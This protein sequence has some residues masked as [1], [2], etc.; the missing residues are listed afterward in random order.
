M[1][2]R[3]VQELGDEILHQDPSDSIITTLSLATATARLNERICYGGFSAQELWTQR[4][5]FM[6]EQIPVSDRDVI[7]Q[8]HHKH[9]ANHP[10]SERFKL[11]SGKQLTSCSVDVGDLVYLYC[12]RNKSK[13]RD[14]YLVISVEGDCCNIHKLSGAQLHCNSYHVKHTEC[15]KVLSDLPNST[16]FRYVSDS[17]DEDDPQQSPANAPLE[18]PVIPTEIA[19]PPIPDTPQ[20]P[21]DNLIASQSSLFIQLDPLTQML[22]VLD[23]LTNF[24]V[25]ITFHITANQ[26]RSEE[27]HVP[28]NSL[29]T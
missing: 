22:P 4:N 25:K 1:A 11:P 18:L 8:Q 10:A 16:I 20:Q 3:A 26:N 6:N 29:S 2:E 23:P 5:Q 7:L 15:Y 24:P 12:D 21:S 28:E 19:T 14:C 9:L 17:S 27:V 13:A